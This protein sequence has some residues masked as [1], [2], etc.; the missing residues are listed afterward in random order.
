M[1]WFLFALMLVIAG[2]VRSAA[3]DGPALVL[4]RSILLP[5]V[6]GRLDH[7]AYDPET[8]RLFVAALGNGSLEVI[9]L[10]KGERVKSVSGLDEVQGVVYLPRTGRVV[11]ACGGDGTVRAF[12]AGTLEEKKRIAVGD[13]ADNAH[14]DGG[15]GSAVLVAHSSGMITRLDAATLEKRAEFKLAD[16]PEGFAPEPDGSRIYAN[17]PGGFIGGGGVVAVIDTKKETK[18]GAKTPPVTTWELKEAGRN[19]PMALDATH[20]RLYVGCRRSARLLVLDTTSG[21]VIASPACVGDADDIFVDP[22]SGRIYVI[23]G[24]DGG[25]IDTFET[26]DRAAYTRGTSTTTTPGARTGLLVPERRML[27][28]AVPKRGS[29]G[30][31]VREYAL[32]E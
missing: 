28:V 19:F 8:K 32:P 26:T 18:D 13:D 4:K 7:L 9:D 5:G 11:V 2:C 24:D 23:G 22:K 31:E 12:D 16:H 14:L 27:Y 25:L 1:K 10:E 6:T 3:N 17:V 29:R 20:H 21:K 15:D 30:A